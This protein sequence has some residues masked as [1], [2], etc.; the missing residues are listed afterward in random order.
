MDIKTLE[1]TGNTSRGYDQKPSFHELSSASIRALSRGWTSTEN[2]NGRTG[3]VMPPF[4]SCCL[5]DL[6]VSTGTMKH[7][8]GTYPSNRT[9]WY[10]CTAVLEFRTQP[11]KL[12]FAYCSLT[13]GLWLGWYR[14]WSLPHTCPP[15][16]ALRCYLGRCP[17]P[18]GTPWRTVWPWTG[19]IRLHW[20][21]KNQANERR[22]SI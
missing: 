14:P 8:L 22:K 13:R 2:L 17:E 3:V 19:T 11:R 7:T 10:Q 16:R 9:D 15:S 1:G 20:S 21:R 4:S 12:P 6:R 18:W 5:K